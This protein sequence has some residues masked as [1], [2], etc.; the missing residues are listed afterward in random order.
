MATVPFHH[1]LGVVQGFL[2]FSR[3]VALLIC[4]VALIVLAGWWW[5]WPRL[6]TVWPGQAAMTA[7]A[8]I[9]FV[10]SSVSLLASGSASVRWSRL[11]HGLSLVVLLLGAATLADFLGVTEW[12]VDRLLGDPLA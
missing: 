8:A 11:G 5:N 7:S 10:L 9:G 4:V 6:T 12:D 3:V 2:R 1:D